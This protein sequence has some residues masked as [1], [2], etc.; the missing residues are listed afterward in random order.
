[1]TLKT[2]IKIAA[3]ATLVVP[4]LLVASVAAQEDNTVNSSLKVQTAQTTVE[5][6]AE[7]KKQEL[8]DR[9]NKRK[10]ELKIKLT[11]A[12]KTRL[13]NRC[14]AAQGLLSSLEGRIKGIETSRTQVYGNLEERL[15]KLSAKLKEAGLDT[16]TLDSQLET[17]SQ[18]I[19]IFETDLAAYKQAV[20]DLAA[21]DCEADPEAFK[22]SLEEARTLRLKLHQSSLDIR[23][24]VK[25]TIKP[26]LAQLREQLK[27]KSEGE[28]Q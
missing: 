13:Q 7:Q 3:S 24:Y 17:L 25:E 19:D 10:T 1:M 15:E 11:T 28:E 2:R 12:A 9:L 8:L 22:A 26:T 20:A 18:K 6:T 27:T 21:M 14:K 5:K 23:I 4:L 16:T